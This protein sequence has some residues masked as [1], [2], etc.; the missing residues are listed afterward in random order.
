MQQIICYGATFVPP[1]SDF[2]HPRSTF[3]GGVDESQSLLQPF[4]LGEDLAGIARRPFAAT[5]QLQLT[6]N[7]GSAKGSLPHSPW[8][9]QNTRK[10]AT[11]SKVLLD[12]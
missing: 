10:E 2:R 7:S 1:W 12:A 9:S 4:S 6:A 3:P 8:A 5:A 11:G